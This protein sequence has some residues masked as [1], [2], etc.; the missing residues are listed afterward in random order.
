MFVLFELM[1]VAA[2]GLTAYKTD[3]P[4]PLEGSFNFA[5]SNSIGAFL[6]LFGIGL[7]YGRTRALNL[8]QL[9]DALAARRADALVICAFTLIV[10]GFLVKAA[11]V[12]FHFWL[13]DAH[14]VAPAPVCLL[15]SGVMVELG[16][17]GVAQV[18]WQVFS[19]VLDA[20]AALRAVLVGFGVL[21]AA[22]G[23]V[24]CL[25]QHHLKRLLALSTV[26]HAGLVLIGVG[27]LGARGLAGA[28]VYVVGHG[29]VKGALFLSAG[30]I[31][32]RTGKVDDHHL[33]GRCRDLPATAAL[34]T[35]GGLALAGL[36]PFATYLGKG[37]LDEA[38]H[39]DGLAWVAVVGL[40]AS[41]VTG[42]AVL[43]AGGH[44]FL[45]WGPVDE[46]DATSD[47]QGAEE[48]REDEGS[49]SRTP[50]VLVGPVVA[51]LVGAVAVGLVPGLTTH[52]ES[53]ADRFVDRAASA[54]L[55]LHGTTTVRVEGVASH[56][57]TGSMVLFGL[58]GALGAVAVAAVALGR[59]RIPSTIADPVR[60]VLLPPQ[61]ALRAAHSGHVGDY[62]AWLTFGTAALGAAVTLAVHH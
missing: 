23:A 44:M 58:L 46:S 29:L 3:E 42:G 41:A 52:V 5:V 10:A 43:R 33:H 9:G 28:A 54:Q 27:L 4:G 38:A 39:A 53:A 57:P 60:R 62:V 13:A 17:F 40:V 31:L 6:V 48:Q 32:H 26:S 35:V 14:A 25:S 51:L 36:P 20:T 18:Y 59:E 45:G 7:L 12:P 37:M 24:M 34:W 55:V 16:L 11:T 22:V 15:F 1:S 56:G 50:L 8:A 47:R 21:S 2:Y 19:G 61:R 49:P 30:I